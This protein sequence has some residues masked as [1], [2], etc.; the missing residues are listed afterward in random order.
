[1]STVGGQSGRTILPCRG[2]HLAIAE[3]EEGGDQEERRGKQD[4]RP[5]NE[6]QRDAR[7]DEQYCCYGRK[8]R[9]QECAR[10]S[11]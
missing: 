9:G 7:H 3:R 4:L 6:E 2:V 8:D 5:N 10:G 11:H 1:M